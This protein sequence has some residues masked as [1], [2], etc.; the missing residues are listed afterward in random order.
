MFTIWLLIRLAG[1]I[2]QKYDL[3]FEQIT[4]GPIADIWED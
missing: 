4:W 2:A 3:T 1:K